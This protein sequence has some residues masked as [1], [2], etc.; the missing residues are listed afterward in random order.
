MAQAF[1]CVYFKEL[2]RY[3]KCN[4]AQAMPCAMVLRT[5]LGIHLQQAF[6][7]LN[8]VSLLQKEFANRQFTH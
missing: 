6:Y 4:I 8:A 2:N 1:F 5:S 3:K 7:R